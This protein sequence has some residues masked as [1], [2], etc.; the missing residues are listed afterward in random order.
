MNNIKN[1][2]LEDEIF[3]TSSDSINTLEVQNYQDEIE[4]DIEDDFID[5][6]QDK[7]SQIISTNIICDGKGFKELIESQ[8]NG[9]DSTPPDFS[10]YI[11]DN[12]RIS[13]NEF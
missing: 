2:F 8:Q 12:W 3:G 13:E 10:K 4:G 6:T 5:N 11:F 9:I 7:K 1:S